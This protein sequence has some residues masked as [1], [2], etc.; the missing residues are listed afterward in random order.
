MNISQSFVAMDNIQ[1]LE[2]QSGC[3]SLAKLAID[4]YERIKQTIRP[5][6]FIQWEKTLKK[7]DTKKYV[8]EH[9][10]FNLLTTCIINGLGLS[11]RYTDPGT[12]Q[13]VAL[14]RKLEH[15][16]GCF[17]HLSDDNSFRSKI[18][19]LEGFN[20]LATLSELSL[21]SYFSKAGMAVT[22]ENRFCKLSD[23]NRKDIDLTLTDVHGE[24]IHLEVYSP[25]Q[26]VDAEG[27]ID[28]NEG[29]YHYAY[30]LAKKSLDKFGNDGIAGLSGKIFL[31]INTAFFDSIQ[32]Q[33]LHGLETIKHLHREALVNLPQGVDG[34]LQFSDD[35]SAEHSLRF[36]GFYVHRITP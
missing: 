21:A 34:L 18:G 6:D 5:S 32:I 14:L 29:N 17:P 2:T 28:P 15:H 16:L 9:S 13:T 26:T 1:L 35:F 3:I 33:K 23:G 7:Q 11:E 10:P 20:F 27:F 4:R 25:F 36:E 24:Q 19:N 30:K 22:F 12:L 31:A 8:L